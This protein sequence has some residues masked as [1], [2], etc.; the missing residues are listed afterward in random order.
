PLVEEQYKK[1]TR[2]NQT[3]QAFYDDLLGK[4]NQSKMATDL[5]K[6]QEGEQ[7]RVMDEPNLP[8]APFSPKR[9]VFAAGGI[10][11]GIAIGLLIVAGMEYKDTSFRSEKDVWA[12]TKI[13]TLAVISYSA[14]DFLNEQKK[15]GWLSRIFRRKKDPFV[16]AGEQNV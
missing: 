9:S 11:G 7:F 6:R 10:A 15:P 3:A 4:M 16:P 14:P 2:D 1:L 8:D 13:P 12:F 5:E